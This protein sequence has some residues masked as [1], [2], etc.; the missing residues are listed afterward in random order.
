MVPFS[1]WDP[2]DNASMSF[3]SRCSP[4]GGVKEPESRRCFFC[5]CF[6]GVWIPDIIL[7]CPWKLVTS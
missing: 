2:Y 4:V 1:G 5:F 7:G 3:A 6:W